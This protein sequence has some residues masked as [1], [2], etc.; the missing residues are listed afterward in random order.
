MQVYAEFE[1]AGRWRAADGEA[2][3][4]AQ[5]QHALGVGKHRVDGGTTSSPPYA[6]GSGL[7]GRLARQGA[8]LCGAGSPSPGPSL[9]QFTIQTVSFRP[10][11]TIL[12]LTRPR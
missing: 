12:L 10:A 6:S 7:H 2:Q 9:S 8:A 5:S 4:T 11:N 1:F 3:A